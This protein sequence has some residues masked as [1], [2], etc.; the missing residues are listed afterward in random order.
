MEFNSS[1]AIAYFV[2]SLKKSTTHYRKW[3][4]CSNK[5]K[6]EFYLN[7]YFEGVKVQ[8]Y[9]NKTVFEFSHEDTA[10]VFDGEIFK[11]IKAIKENEHLQRRNKFMPSL[12]KHYDSNWTI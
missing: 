7:D 10:I 9:A 3:R 5:L 8:A 12:K 2:D 11:A 4:P 1:D 6:Q